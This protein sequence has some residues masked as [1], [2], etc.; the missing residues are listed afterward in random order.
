MSKFHYFEIET[1]KVFNVFKDFA[2]LESKE[3]GN[4]TRDFLS[5]GLGKFI[6][7]S[8]I[9][10]TFSAVIGNLSS[11]LLRAFKLDH[12]HKIFRFKNQWYYIFSGEVLSFQKFEKAKGLHFNSLPEDQ[13][14]LTTYA[15]LLIAN[16]EGN[17]E[18]YTGFVV[19]YDLNQED[20]SQLDKIYLLDAY[21]YKK[22]NRSGYNDSSIFQSISSTNNSYE[23][24]KFDDEDNYSSRKRIN[25]PGDLLVVS[26]KNILNINLTYIPSKKIE[27]QREAKKQFRFKWLA[28]FLTATTL[29][30]IFIHFFS[31]FI[32]FGRNSALNSYFNKS[33]FWGKFFAIIYINQVIALIFPVKNKK[34]KYY[35]SKNTTMVKIFFL[36]ILSVIL[37]Y[38]IDRQVICTPWFLPTWI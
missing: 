7:Y 27:E 8:L 16:L 37:Y 10:F 25:I 6:F 1:L 19:D 22:P 12:K 30:I 21:R 4:D 13:K 24:S 28:Y 20:I 18:L 33:T 26:G 14:I 36:L 15:D 32:D 2:Y 23:F 35:F 31:G 34:G 11:R 3:V 29:I 17:R 5:Y 38:L 9:I